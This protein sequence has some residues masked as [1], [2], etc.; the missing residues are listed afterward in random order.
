[1]RIEEEKAEYLGIL[2]T[3]V[4]VFL[5]LFGIDGPLI[6][7]SILCGSILIARQ[8]KGKGMGGV[9][10]PEEDADSEDSEI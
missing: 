2:L 8:M 9:P 10:E 1:M 6:A 7:G 3:C 4:G 5:T